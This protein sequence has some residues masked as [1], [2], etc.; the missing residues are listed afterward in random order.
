MM[1][2]EHKIPPLLA[3][4]G[5][6][7]SRLIDAYNAAED[8]A[9][10]GKVEAVCDNLRTCF[11]LARRIERRRKSTRARRLFRKAMS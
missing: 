6:D 2:A 9:K 3:E 5:W 7:L 8:A 11:D 1:E 4:T 10:R